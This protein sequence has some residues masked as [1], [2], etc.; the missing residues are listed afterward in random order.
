MDGATDHAEHEQS[1]LGVTASATSETSFQPAGASQ[2]AAPAIIPSVL[3]HM[4]ASLLSSSSSVQ[5]GGA[6]PAAAVPSLSVSRKASLGSGKNLDSTAT[7]V[8][9]TRA[10]RAGESAPAPQADVCQTLRFVLVDV[11]R[12][13]SCRIGRARHARRLRHVVRVVR[14]WYWHQ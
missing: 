5:G 2:P 6:L 4:K 11:E 14:T 12:A 3:Q 10:F 1:G 13:R 8:A 9:A 7:V